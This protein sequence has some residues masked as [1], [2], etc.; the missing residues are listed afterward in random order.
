MKLRLFLMAAAAAAVTACQAETPTTTETTP[1]ADMAST[2]PM[3]T[4]PAIAN[5]MFACT[6]DTRLAVTISD[7]AADV[8]VNEGASM[9]LPRQ[10]ESD[11]YTD[12]AATLTLERPNVR[13][14]QGA[15][16]AQTCVP[17][18]MPADPAT[19]Q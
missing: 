7:A 15:Q 10:G 5:Q 3:A 4:T 6:D 8:S 1:P 13:F 11:V 16:A 2:P 19:P 9:T 14:A 17:A 12:G 18:A